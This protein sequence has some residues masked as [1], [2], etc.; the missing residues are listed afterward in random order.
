M[1]LTELTTTLAIAGVLAT[2]AIPGM[3]SLVARSRAD[4]AARQLHDAVQFARHLAV[5]RRVVATLCPGG[6]SRCG[7]RDTWHEGAIVFLDDNANG[8]LEAS[9][10]VALRLPPLATGYRVYWRSFRNR[11]SLSMLP[12]GL[13]DWQN[14]HLLVCPPD[15]DPKQARLLV[16]NAHGRARLAKDD[17]GDGIVESADGRPV[18]C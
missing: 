2:A 11:K 1:T 15:D 12:T 18:A 13:T 9:E 7:K 8:R 5:A 17:D 3:S 6:G 14:G 10:E 4:D 16:V